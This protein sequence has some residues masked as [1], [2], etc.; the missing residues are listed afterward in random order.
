MPS[1]FR[2]LAS[3]GLN[4]NFD[5]CGLKVEPSARIYAVWEREKA[6]VDTLGT[7]QAQRNF[8][9][10]RASGGVKVAYPFAWT[11]AITLAPYV[12]LYGDYYF[13]TDDPK[14]VGAGFTRRGQETWVPDEHARPANT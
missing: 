8:S 7:L 14:V 11:S 4:G 12:G 6:Y 9:T 13:N 2:W 10:G 5:S 3:G 1:A